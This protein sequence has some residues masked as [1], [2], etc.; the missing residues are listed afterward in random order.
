MLSG[1]D[2]QSLDNVRVSN[3]DAPFQSTAYTYTGDPICA[4]TPCPDPYAGRNLYD[5]PYQQPNYLPETRDVAVP[6]GRLKVSI[7][8]THEWITGF[9]AGSSTWTDDTIMRIEPRLFE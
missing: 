8:L 1:A 7:T 3:P 6:P 9:F 4:W 2:L 5:P